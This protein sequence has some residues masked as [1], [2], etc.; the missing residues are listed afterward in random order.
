MGGRIDELEA[1]IGELMAQAGVEE[2]G[3]AE[4]DGE[5]TAES[6]ID[7]KYLKGDV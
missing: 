6:Q 1:S 2:E 3:N 4:K 5:A 7:A